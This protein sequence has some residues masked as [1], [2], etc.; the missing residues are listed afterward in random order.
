MQMLLSVT[1]E[2]EKFLIF[3]LVSFSVTRLGNLLHFGQLFKAFGNN[4]IYQIR[5][6]F[7]AIFE[8]SFIFYVE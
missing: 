2:N 6:H 4:Y 3:F 1:N 8:N 7:N 5:P